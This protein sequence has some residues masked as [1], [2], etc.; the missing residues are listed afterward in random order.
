MISKTEQYVMSFIYSKVQI[1]QPNFEGNQC[2]K[3]PKYISRWDIPDISWV[4]KCYVRE[5]CNSKSLEFA[6][7]WEYEK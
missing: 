6:M 1:L 5:R 4:Q 7:L 3:I 2:R